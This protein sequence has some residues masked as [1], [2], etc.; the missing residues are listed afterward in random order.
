MTVLDP[1]GS[2][3]ILAACGADETPALPGKTYSEVR[4]GAFLFTMSLAGRGIVVIDEKGRLTYAEVVPTPQ[5]TYAT[6]ELDGTL[7]C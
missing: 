7:L 4:Y 2:A 3:A 6:P 5:V 1:P